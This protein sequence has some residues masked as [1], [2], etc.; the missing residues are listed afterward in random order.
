MKNYVQ[1]GNMITV[2][3]PA[4]VSSGGGVQIGS[5]FGVAA[6]DAALGADVEIATNGVFD[7]TKPDAEAV[8]V[9]DDLY[10]DDTA[11]EVTNVAGANL[12]VGVAIAAA[13]GAD[14]TVRVRLN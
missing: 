12:L 5:L 8:S 6:G 3:A 1:P 14:A 7:M 13:A 10:W 4:A 11:K 2:S 9:G